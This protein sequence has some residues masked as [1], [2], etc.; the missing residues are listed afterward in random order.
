M[1]NDPDIRFASSLVDYVFR[2]LALD[3]LSLEQARVLGIRSIDERKVEATA[4]RSSSWRQARST[5]AT[6]SRRSPRRRQRIEMR[7]KHGREDPGRAAV[8]PVRLEDAAGR[9][10]LRLRHCGSTS[11]CS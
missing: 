4:R 5:E 3:H 6:P 10:L 2:R 11:G 8:L 7:E 1:T 9:L